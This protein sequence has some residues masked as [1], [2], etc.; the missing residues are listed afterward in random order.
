LLLESEDGRTLND[1]AFY[2]IKGGQYS[3]AIPFAQKAVHY[4]QAGSVV[5]G[6]ATF[7]LGLALLKAGR[8]VDALPYLQR[9]LRIEAKEQ[10]PF[11]RPRVTQAKSCA[12]RGGAEQAQSL[13]AGAAKAPSKGP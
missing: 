11:I 13:S 7:N 10:R 3:R 9:A 8:C 5:R 1:A 4:T 2:L 12:R 6:Y